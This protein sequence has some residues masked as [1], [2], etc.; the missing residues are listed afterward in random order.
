M[1][2]F[3]AFLHSLK[4]LFCVF[5]NYDE[6]QIAKKLIELFK[7]FVNKTMTKAEYLAEVKKL[8]DKQS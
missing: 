7:A 6:N 4:P 1:V 8:S 3:Y 5:Q 2:Y